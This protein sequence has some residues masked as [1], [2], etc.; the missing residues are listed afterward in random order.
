MYV[1][2]I[3]NKLFHMFCGF[4]ELDLIHKCEDLSVLRQTFMSLGRRNYVPS[5]VT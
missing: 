3:E 5:D 4:S 1:K 2:I